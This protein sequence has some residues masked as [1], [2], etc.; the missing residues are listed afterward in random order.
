[1]SRQTVKWS[2]E[3]KRETSEKAVSAES[4]G[5]S[6]VEPVD[7]L[8]EAIPSVAAP[9]DNETDSSQGQ[10][11]NEP[12][13]EAAPPIWESTGGAK[14]E[15]KSRQPRVRRITSSD[16]N[17]TFSTFMM[18]PKTAAPSTGLA[19]GKTNEYTK[20]RSWDVTQEMAN[21]KKDAMISE[22]EARLRSL[23]SKLNP[24][25]RPSRTKKKR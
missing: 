23:E 15:M 24:M 12:P 22:L 11:S 25:D 14:P 7:P 2:F 17:P 4:P 21:R 20:T 5:G 1:M 3:R 18:Q 19:R 6:G 8:A 16:S 13:E 10:G 9:G